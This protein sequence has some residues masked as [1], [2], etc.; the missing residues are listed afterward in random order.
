MV[1]CSDTAMQQAEWRLYEQVSPMSERG[2]D[3]QPSGIEGGGHVFW[4]IDPVGQC[5]RWPCLSFL[6]NLFYSCFGS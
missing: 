1:E 3:K 2:K 5:V 4:T 6:I